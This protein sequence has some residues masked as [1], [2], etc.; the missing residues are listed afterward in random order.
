[1]GRETVYC[2]LC[3]ERIPP[4]QL[5]KGIALK[6]ESRAF[7]KQC[8]NE[9]PNVP[10]LVQPEV[11][12][13][14]KPTPKREAAP[15]Q[16]RKPPSKQGAVPK[17]V[18]RRPAA[19]AG[20]A[21]EEPPPSRGFPIWFGVTLAIIPLIGVLVVV[22]WPSGGEPPPVAPKED[23]KPKVDEAA[24]LKRELD[25]VEK[26]DAIVKRARQ[27]ADEKKFEEAVKALDEFPPSMK[28]TKARA[29]IDEARAEIGKAQEA[30][31]KRP[32]NELVNDA[33]AAWRSQDYELAKKI[34]TRAMAGA[35]PSTPS[36][37]Q[38]FHEHWQLA[39]FHLAE[40]F[41]KEHKTDDCFAH[42]DK[43]FQIRTSKGGICKCQ[44]GY[45]EQLQSRDVWAPIRSDSRYSALLDSVKPK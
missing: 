5:E 35:P 20:P 15:P 44:G 34:Y 28:D 24:K 7:C 39:H 1:M 29:G 14:Y 9:N 38:E 25:A 4:E 40:L 17:E 42:L 27:L 23:P 41:A 3:G 32:W 37:S 21:P 31:A 36:G 10:T 45:L 13:F 6:L 30:E 22:L 43:V 33:I 12:P 18:A 11:S 26:R 8:I 2:A 16:V 19:E